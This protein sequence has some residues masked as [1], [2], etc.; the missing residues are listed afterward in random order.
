QV[1]DVGVIVHIQLFT[2]LK[3]ATVLEIGSADDFHWRAI[4]AH[5]C[6]RRRLPPG[7]HHRTAS[8]VDHDL[9]VGVGPPLVRVHGG[10]DTGFTN[11]FAAPEFVFAVRRIPT[12]K[13]ILRIAVR[14][15]APVALLLCLVVHRQPAAHHF[16]HFFTAVR[17]HSVTLYLI[18]PG[19]VG[20]HYE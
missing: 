17:G 9:V 10:T 7:R 4:F 19:N 13:T 3:I 5:R 6:T 20:S 8:L 1:G 18:K 14:Q 12:V 2:P 11:D 15:M 16:F